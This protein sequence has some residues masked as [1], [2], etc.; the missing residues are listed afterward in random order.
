V[1]HR[2]YNLCAASPI[3]RL[4]LDALLPLRYHLPPLLGYEVVAR[5]LVG[6][7]LRVNCLKGGLRCGIKRRAKELAVVFK[8][9]ADATREVV[10]GLV[11]SLV[12]EKGIVPLSTQV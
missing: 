3:S 11:L 12:M 5:S 4:A 7:L 2:R 8:A 6:H 9:R 10:R 1:A